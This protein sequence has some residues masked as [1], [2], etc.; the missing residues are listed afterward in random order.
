MTKIDLDDGV[1]YFGNM[2]FIVVGD[3]L[4]AFHDVF[5]CWLIAVFYLDSGCAFRCRHDKRNAPSEKL[6]VDWL[7]P[8]EV[9]K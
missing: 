6:M 3:A 2:A 8:K 4:Q 7:W 5:A 1:L 9:S